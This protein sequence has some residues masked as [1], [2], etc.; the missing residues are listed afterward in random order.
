MSTPSKIVVGT[1]AASLV[2][3]L[4]LVVIVGLTT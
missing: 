3:A 1:L 2:T 4:A